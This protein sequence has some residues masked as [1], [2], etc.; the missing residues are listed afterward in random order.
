MFLPARQIFRDFP[1]RCV[2]R[3][4]Q[5][6]R[7]RSI[8]GPIVEAACWAHARLKF[9]ELADLAKA[10][11]RTARS[12]KPAFTSPTA[13]EAVLIPVERCVYSMTMVTLSS[14]AGDDYFD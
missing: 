4:Q 14:D 9:F 3:V 8:T 10:A 5:T 13:L 6:L 7:G 2:Q 11:R 1:G 12:G